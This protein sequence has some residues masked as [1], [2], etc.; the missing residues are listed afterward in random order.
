MVYSDT[1]IKGLIHDGVLQSADENRVGVISY[2][3]RTEGFYRSKD[4]GGKP[5]V[6]LQPGDSVFVGTVETISLPDDVCATVALRNSRIRQGLQLAAPVYF[7]GHSTRIF[8]RLTNISAD[9]IEL[10]KADSFAQVMFSSVE[11]KVE[12]PYSGAFSGEMDYS[13]MGRYEQ[14]YSAQMQKID[15]KID[16]LKS[17]ESRIYGNVMTIMTIIAAVFSLVS[18]N[19]QSWHVGLTG[20]VLVNAVIVASFSALAGLLTLVTRPK[21]K[22]AYVIPWVA[23]AVLYVVAITLAF[24]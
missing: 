7:P 20:I 1:N 4:E 18:V 12:K 16:D 11:G 17:L 6:T 23:A 9:A 2:D 14:Q 22:S 10:T 3:L 8:F 19:T 5:L 13:G 24:I 15:K 21:Q